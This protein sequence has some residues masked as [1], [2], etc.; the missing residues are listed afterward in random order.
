[1]GK[2]ATIHN[3]IIVK[4]SGG[5]TEVTH[6]ITGSTLDEVKKGVPV[7]LKPYVDD[8]VYYGQEKSVM[9]SWRY[10]IL[11]NRWSLS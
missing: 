2:F 10:D 1:M 4:T 6:N 5:V 3:I 11:Y 8:A 9:G 7:G